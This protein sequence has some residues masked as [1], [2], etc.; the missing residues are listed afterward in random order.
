MSAPKF[1]PG[2]EDLLD[3]AYINS[4]PQPFMGR[5]LGGSKWPVYDLDVQ[6]GLVRIDVSGLLQVTHIAEFTMFSDA[7]GVEHSAEGFYADAL[8][9]DRTALAKAVRP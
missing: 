1:T 7:F 4:L 8:P 3:M 6:T 2:P 5:M 9:E